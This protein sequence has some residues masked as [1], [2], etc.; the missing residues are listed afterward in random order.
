MAQGDAASQPSRH[1]RVG[2]E[3]CEHLLPIEMLIEVEID[4]KA[5]ALGKVEQR[6]QRARRV[7]AGIETC[8]DHVGAESDGALE[9]RECGR[10][11]EVIS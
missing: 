11:G 4:G 1:H 2:D 9:P 5:R 6:R 7:G 3:G 8:A 10:L